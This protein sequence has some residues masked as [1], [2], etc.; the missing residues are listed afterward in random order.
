MIFQTNS[1]GK[2]MK[3]TYKNILSLEKNKKES[4]FKPCPIRKI[5]NRPSN[6]DGFFFF[7]SNFNSS[8]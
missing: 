6:L 3:A 8:D 1:M 4:C 5:E 7:F 2:T